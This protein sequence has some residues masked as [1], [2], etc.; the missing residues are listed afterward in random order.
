MDIPAMEIRVLGSLTV[1]C[2]GRSAVPSAPKPRQVA[3]V[4]LLNANRV[5]TVAAL[6]RELWGEEP[7]PSASTTLQT[8]ILQF[9]KLLAAAL[10][11]PSKVIAS[12]VLTTTS[13][14]Y[15]FIAPP[16]AI[17]VHRYEQL[18]AEGRGALSVGDN[19]SAATLLRAALAVWRDPVLVDVRPGSVLRVKIERLAESRLGAIEQRIEADV[20]LGRHHEVLSELIELTAEHRLHESMHAQLILALY[21]SGRRSHALAAYRSL[22][23]A[24]TE[25]L[26]LE[27][28]L[29]VARLHQAILASDP[30]LELQG[31]N[32]ALAPLDRL[33]APPAAA[34]A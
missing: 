28:S 23:A 24:L 17:D 2:D 22:R 6:A 33:T 19:E 8:Y 9:R 16:D 21:R 13:V 10:Q 27:P 5:V 14:G 26:G 25:E 34:R 18:L 30:A 12:Q 4:L 29:R 31:R 20:R 11:V 3:G 1:N 32:G 15:Q 7:P